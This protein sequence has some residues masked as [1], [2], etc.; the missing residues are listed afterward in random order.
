[1]T[2][3]FDTEGIEPVTAV[4][5]GIDSDGSIMLK[6]IYKYSELDDDP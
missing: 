5:I 4:M 6:N 3:S 1:V 2:G